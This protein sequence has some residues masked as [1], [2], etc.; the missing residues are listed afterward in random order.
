LALGH[1]TI[2]ALASVQIVPNMSHKF[3][4]EWHQK[5]PG[6]FLYFFWQVPGATIT[7]AD[8]NQHMQAH[9]GVVLVSGLYYLI[10]ESKQDGSAFRSVNCYSS[11]DLVTWTFVNQVLKLQGIGDLGR[12]RVIERPHTMYNDGTKKWV[13]WMHV[14]SSNYGEAKAGVATCDTVCGDYTYM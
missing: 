12:N 8:T 9:G 5:R 4:S 13:M 14:D 3:Q 1:L 6:N 11:P 10:G 2:P 7:A